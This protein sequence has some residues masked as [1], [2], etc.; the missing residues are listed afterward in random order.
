MNGPAEPGAMTASERF[1]EF[2]YDPG[3]I[4]CGEG[5]AA[6]LGPALDREGLDRAMVVTGRTVGSTPAVMDPVRDGLGDRLVAEFAETTPEKYL[7][8]GLDAA[9]R[10][11]ELDVDVL[12]AVGSGSSLDVTKVASALSSHDRDPRAV[13]EEAIEDGAVPVADDGNPLPIAVAP[14]TLAGADLSVV[15]GVTLTLDPDDAS[16]ADA[17]SGSVSDG[18]L[19]PTALCYDPDLFR[20]TPKS[21]LTAS[22]MNGF[23]KAVESLYSRHA[24]PITDGTAMR[25][26]RLLQ[27]GLPTL[28]EDPMDD[29]RL[30]EVISG[31]VLAQYGV[32]T[33]DRYRASVIHAFGHGFSHGYDVHQGTVHGVVAPH[34]LRYVFDRVDGR[35]A[36]LAE[37]F[38]VETDGKTDD[39]LA[40]AVV[41]AVAE[42]RDE[43]GLP[44]RLRAIEG[45]ER[46]D[47]PSIAEAV[48]EDSMLAA[49][50]S[51]LDP[52]ADEVEDVLAA[53]W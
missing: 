45:L 17:P 7:Q 12:V 3:A 28:T 42:V 13:A 31:I 49:A 9:E 11:R 22:A 47:L 15:A 5:A 33:P 44:D 20:T 4:Y 51:G 29:E 26:L 52:T 37:A 6:E 50:P 41:A 19:M 21:V 14:T 40:E 48:V 36:L 34:V 46:S 10:A 43:L 32:S 25:G 53:A 24:T 18:R 35:R 38:G 23:D 30:D 39:E 8:T 2:D 27:S 16:D 1:F